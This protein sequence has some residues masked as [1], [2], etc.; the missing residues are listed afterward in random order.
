LIVSDGI[1]LDRSRGRGAGGD[2]DGDDV[3]VFFEKE[4]YFCRALWQKIPG[5]LMCAR[6][7]KPS[8][9]AHPKKN[10]DMRIK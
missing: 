2:A 7:P 4:P 9:S 1:S 5:R 8:P 3:L 10:T 6:R